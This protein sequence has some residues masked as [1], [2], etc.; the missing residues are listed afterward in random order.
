MKYKGSLKMALAIVGTLAI[1]MIPL[2][3]SGC[4]AV[5]GRAPSG[6]KVGFSI[7]YTGVAAE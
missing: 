7:C 6:L 3:S 2:L 5:G 4:T 1:A